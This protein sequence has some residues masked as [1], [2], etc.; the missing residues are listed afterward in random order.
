MFDGENR[1]PYDSIVMERRC[2]FSD[3]R[4]YRFTLWREW[5]MMNSRYAM[6][7]GLNP[8]T[9]DEIKDD[10]TIRKCIGFAKRWGYGALCMTNLFAFRAT[11]PRKMKGCSKPIGVQNDRWLAACARD[12]AIVVAA[13]GINGEHMGR[14]QEVVKLV[15]NLHYLRSTKHGHP[16]HPLYIPYEITPKLL[17]TL[18]RH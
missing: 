9:A 5:D 16:E 10:P 18:P 2:E 6:F 17:L 7:V 14:D 12:A 13:W 3:D 4:L 8:S 1:A 11:D 15:D